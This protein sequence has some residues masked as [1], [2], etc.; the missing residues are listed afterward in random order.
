MMDLRLFEADPEGSDW[1]V[2]CEGRLGRVVRGSI[3]SRV[4]G[5]PTGYA[6]DPAGRE[7]SIVNRAETPAE[8]LDR[9]FVYGTLRRGGRWHSILADHGAR[10]LHTLEVPGQL[11]DIGRYPGF[12]LGDGSVTGEIWAW[13]EAGPVLTDLDALED[14]LGYGR[15]GS[16]YRRIII[17]TER[18]PAWT[19]LHLRPEL[20]RGVVAS[21]DWMR[22]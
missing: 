21:G 4:A 22:R 1:W 15:E 9:V 10:Y 6:L 11:V 19:Y 14:F 18:G 17:D 7:V 2:D 3:L 20:V 8:S 13:D 5:A 16:E 12:V